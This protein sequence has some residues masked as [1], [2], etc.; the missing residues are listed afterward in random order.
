M[1]FP[2]TNPPTGSGTRWGGRCCGGSIARSIARSRILDQRRRLALPIVRQA[3]GRVLASRR[4]FRYTRDLP[5]L[6]ATGVLLVSCFLAG[7]SETSSVLTT[8]AVPTLLTADPQK[9]RGGVQCGA[10]ELQAYVVA[11]TDVSPLPTEQL[12]LVP[13]STPSAC[14]NPT[15]FGSPP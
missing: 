13:V 6:R 8:T 11:V 15:S 14:P 2:E 3:D 9:F 5:M 1:R 10:P 4:G 7:C 12:G